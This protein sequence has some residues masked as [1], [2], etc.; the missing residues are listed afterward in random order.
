MKRFLT[1]FPRAENVHLVKDVGM[2]P[3]ILF[4]SKNYEST[5]A[6]YKLGSYPYLETEVPGLRQLFIKRYFNAIVPD[7]FLFLLKHRNQ[8][9]ILQLYHLDK[10]SLLLSLLFKLLHGKK[11]KVY[12]KLDAN[13]LIRNKKENEIKKWLYHYLLS[14][15]DLVSVETNQLQKELSEKWNID[16]Q[17]IANGFYDNGE[18]SE[19]L[20]SEKENIILTVGRIGSYV[21]ATEILCEGFR[22]FAEKDDQWALEIVGPI[23]DSFHV[24]IENYFKKYPQLRKRVRFTGPITDR[25]QLWQFYRKAK[26]FVLPSRWEGFALVYLEAARAGCYIISTDISPAFDI[27]RNGSL[28]SIF[29]KNDPE[30]L[31]K[32]LWHVTQDATR[33]K[34]LCSAIQNNVY[35][36]YYWPVLCQKIDTLIS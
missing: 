3:Y 11:V 23:D 13:D 22:Q 18:R 8:F 2:I 25:K 30:A 15:I 10:N 31:S 24:Y 7:V 1:V 4:K 20:F 14:K 36:H 33:L 19:V 5:I 34:S 32:L 9:D 29:P 21:K 28:G 27:T 35:D 6:S 16:I 26:I 12:L 17:C